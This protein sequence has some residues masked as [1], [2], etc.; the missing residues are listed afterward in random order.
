MTARLN[1]TSPP[2]E[3]LFSGPTPEQQAELDRK[4]EGYKAE[5]EAIFARYGNGAENI[6][7]C[8]CGNL[9]TACASLAALEAEDTTPDQANLPPAPAVSSRRYFIDQLAPYGWEVTD[10]RY[11]RTR[12]YDRAASALEGVKRMEAEHPDGKHSL[13]AAVIEWRPTTDAG[14]QI[15]EHIMKENQ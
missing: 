5:A 9:V 10:L 1:T 13:L 7:G 2:M 11:G 14:R 8:G 12:R 15:V 3:G 6:C 4:D